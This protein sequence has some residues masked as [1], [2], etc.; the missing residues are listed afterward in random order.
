MSYADTLAR[1]WRQNILHSVLV[2]LTYRCNLDCSFCYNDTSLQG[3]PLTTEQYFRFFNDLL[4]LGT[5]NLT[6]SGGEPLAHP[7]FFA[8][9]SKARELGFVVRVKT[10]G[11][12]LR[13]R[14]AQRV[15]DEVDPFVVEVS[16]HGACAATHDRQTRV[17]GSFER[18]IA[19]LRNARALGLRLKLNSALT[20][21]NEDEIEAMHAIADELESAIQFDP[22]ITRRDDGDASP[23]ALTASPAGIARLF[24]IQNRRAAARRAV[25]AGTVDEGARDAAPPGSPAG[26][27]H[28]GA[29]SSTIVV[30]PFGNVYPCV[31]WRRRIGNLHVDSVTTLWNQSAELADVRRI[32]AE[33]KTMV[34]AH[35][36][37]GFAFC[38]G[39]AE[40]ETGS[41]R[42]LYP[43]A[44]LLLELRRRIPAQ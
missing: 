40:H 4:D 7:G 22:Q 11:H 25:D 35:A 5:L 12:A 34:D 31:Q 2:E 17:P 39:S 30:D 28:C 43:V 13:G 38:P 19:N 18:L 27:K 14:L 29:G 9:G 24:E 16:L 33:V 36:T 26:E 37:P 44:K 6:L 20:R 23:L 42:Q 32:T 10:N 3:A 15:R 1:T 41:A 21:W 8:L